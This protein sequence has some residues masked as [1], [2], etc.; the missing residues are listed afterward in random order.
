MVHYNSESSLVVE[1]K[2]NQHLNPLLIELKESVL[3]KFSE[4]LF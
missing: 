2:S 3:S 1:V 4:S